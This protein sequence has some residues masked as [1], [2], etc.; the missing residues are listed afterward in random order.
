MTLDLPEILAKAGKA[1]VD[2]QRPDG[3]FTAGH[4]GPYRD[5]ETPVR[6][7][8]HWLV[9]LC[10]LYRRS[11]EE[12]WHSAAHRAVDYLL[13]DTARPVKASFHCR[14][15]PGKDFCNGL[16][17]QAWAMEGLVAAAHTLERQ[18]AEGTALEVFF[19]H[20][21]L[22]DA[23]IW[24][25]VHVDG[26]RL[27]PDNTFNHQLWFA[28]VGCMLQDPE[29]DRRAVRF[30]EQVGANVETYPTGIVYHRSPV[31]G[32]GPSTSFSAGALLRRVRSAGSRWKSRR[33]TQRK[34]IGYHAFNLYGY[35]LLKQRFPTHPV[36][37]RQVLKNML[38]ATTTPEFKQELDD[39]PYGYPYNPPGLELAFVGEV[40]GLGG[41]YSADWID[42]Q[43][44]RTHDART[45][46][47]LT[48]N[49]PDE[50]T[51]S[52]RIYEATRLRD[53]YAVRLDG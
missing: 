6:N 25:R 21:F 3:S 4:N 7:T 33:S 13:G 47:I 41:R 24:E 46:S 51:S 16:I 20:P 9:T 40:F 31:K 18:D 19:L 27:T 49:V 44:A 28:A 52:A 30:L 8:A 37:E 34:S 2:T 36:W 1:A 48:R 17:G 22:E 11:G 35:A 15:K 50:A 23:A 43:I 32:S 42:A 39:N 45:G 10:D 5:P 26:S 38:H 14:S 29:A 12:I 53:E